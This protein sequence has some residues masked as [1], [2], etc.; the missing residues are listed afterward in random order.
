M[1]NYTTLA[2]DVATWLNRSGMSD[3]T[4]NVETFMAYAQNKIARTVDL[5]QMINTSSFDTDTLT[6]P[7]GLLRVKSFTVVSG[8]D[9]YELQGVPYRKAKNTMGATGRPTYYAIEGSNFILAPTPTQTYTLELTYYAPL[10]PL[11]TGNAT[12]WIGDTYPDVILYGTLL[13]AALFLKDDQRAM[14]WKT[15]FDEAVEEMKKS[16]DIRSF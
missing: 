5:N 12:N 10:T 14:V 6:V 15:K 13:E 2:A 16:D 11:S 3:V 9:A 7:S 1:A 8:G 4:D